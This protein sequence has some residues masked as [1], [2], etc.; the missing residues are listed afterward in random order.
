MYKP[1]SALT[2]DHAKTVLQDGVRAI[3]SGQTDIDLAA[4]TAVDSTAVGTLLAW[5]RAARRQRKTVV[6]H[7]LPSGLRSLAEL[8]GVVELLHPSTAVSS[9][10]DPPHH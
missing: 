1:A 6:F 5:Q 9:P 8:Y 10:A 3:E 4:V 2:F 7:N